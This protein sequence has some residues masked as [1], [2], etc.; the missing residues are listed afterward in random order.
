MIGRNQEV[1]NPNDRRFGGLPEQTAE[2]NANTMHVIGHSRSSD[3]K[4]V[5]EAAN[6]TIRLDLL[7]EM[8]DHQLGLIRRSDHW[9]FLESG[10]PA[11]LFTTGLHPDYHTV[12]DTA[13]RINYSKLEKIT[14]LGFLAAWQ[15]ANDNSRPALNSD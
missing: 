14:R 7:F 5:I 9:P 12:N 6:Q 2:Q 11:F 4:D 3:L 10:V 8:D 15:L 1:P 13:D